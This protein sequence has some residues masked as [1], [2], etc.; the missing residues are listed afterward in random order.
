[1][2]RLKDNDGRFLWSDGLVAGEPARLLGYP[3][4]IEDYQTSRLMPRRLRSVISPG[5][6][7]ERPDLRV[8]RDPFSASHVVLRNRASAVVFDFGAIKLLKF[9]LSL[10]AVGRRSQGARSGACVTRVN[11]ALSSCFLPSKQC[12]A[13]TRPILINL[14]SRFRS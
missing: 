9:G 5:M 2:R 14:S 13:G 1:V 11:L 7:A 8:L 4:L 6:P 3:V 12:E 10:R